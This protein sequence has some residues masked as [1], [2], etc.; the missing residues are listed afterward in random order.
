MREEER[1]KPREPIEAI[2][3]RE[4]HGLS[5]MAAPWNRVTAAHCHMFEPQNRSADPS[6]VCLVLRYH[7]LSLSP[8]SFPLS[9]IPLYLTLSLLFLYVSLIFTLN[10]PFYLLQSLF[11][12]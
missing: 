9:S 6:S 1:E 2:V 8:L 4:S 10:S 12:S 11:L 5:S 3:H 7:S